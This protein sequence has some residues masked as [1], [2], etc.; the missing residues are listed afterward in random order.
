[1][2]QFPERIATS[3]TFELTGANC[4]FPNDRETSQ[5]AAHTVKVSGISACMSL[6]ATRVRNHQTLDALHMLPCI[7]SLEN[8]VYLKKKQIQL[9]AF[10]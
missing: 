8:I 9:H 4:F 7:G 6:Q 2:L 10:L 3:L 5:S 1:M